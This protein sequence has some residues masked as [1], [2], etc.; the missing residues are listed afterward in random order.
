[1]LGHIHAFILG[2]GNDGVGERFGRN[3]C[4]Y[5]LLGDS[6]F[7]FTRCHVI[8]KV[9]HTVDG[10]AF[11]FKI[12]VLVRSGLNDLIKEG[13]KNR[14]CRISPLRGD[15]HIGEEFLGDDGLCNLH[16]RFVGGFVKIF[17]GFNEGLCFIFGAFR[18]IR[19]VNM[20]GDT[21]CCANVCKDALVVQK[22]AVDLL[23]EQRDRG[24]GERLQGIS[25]IQEKADQI[26]KR[27]LQNL[28]FCHS[29]HH[30]ADG[31]QGFQ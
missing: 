19:D 23:P 10:F 9:H 5:E 21:I 27:G 7:R 8:D 24:I 18:F 1:M 29:I 22:T 25:G 20:V 17:D 28:R 26:F 12:D 15:A 3:D 11:G 16:G 14:F 2:Y 6:V 31:C 30:F 13:V 4:V